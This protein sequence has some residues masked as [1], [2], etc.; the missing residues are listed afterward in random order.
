MEGECGEGRKEKDILVNIQGGTN[1]KQ[2]HY[3]IQPRCFH[4]CNQSIQ[5]YN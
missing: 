2:N 3:Y 5:W 1:Y 4:S